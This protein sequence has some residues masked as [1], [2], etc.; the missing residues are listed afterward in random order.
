MAPLKKGGERSCS[1]IDEIM[2][3]EY[4]FDI[5]K[6][7]HGVGFKKPAPQALR[8]TWKFAIKKMG[9][10]DVCIDTRHNKAI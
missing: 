9:A 2:I 3:R 6:C 4:T 5:H 8:E 7:I 10:P 1:A